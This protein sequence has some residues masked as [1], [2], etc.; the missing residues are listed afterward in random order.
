WLINGD[1]LKF[2]N[3]SSFFFTTHHNIGKILYGILGGQRSTKCFLSLLHIALFYFSKS[4]SISIF[5]SIIKFWAKIQNWFDQIWMNNLQNF[6]KEKKNIIA[7][8]SIDLIWSSL[9]SFA[10]TKTH[11]IMG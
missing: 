5:L 2:S 9:V 8:G 1:F 4:K 7:L 6:E 11:V 3:F 10:P